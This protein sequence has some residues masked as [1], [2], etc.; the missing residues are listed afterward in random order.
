MHDVMM[1]IEELG[2]SMYYI[3][4]IAEDVSQEYV[5]IGGVGDCAAAASAAGGAVQLARASLVHTRCAHIH[6]RP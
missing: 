1:Y 4:N 5:C 2:Q 3:G 6:V